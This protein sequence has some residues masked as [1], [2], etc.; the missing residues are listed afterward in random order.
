[1]QTRSRL[2]AVSL[3][4]PPSPAQDIAGMN[5]ELTSAEQIDLARIMDAA[6]NRAREALRVL[7][8]YCRFVLDDAF[9]SGELK[10]L[11][12]ELAQALGEL[13]RDKLLIGRDTLGDVGTRISTAQEGSRAS[14][15]AVVIAN[16]KR[17]QE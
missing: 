2:G 1:M 7:E 6:A 11:R 13:D 8:D 14:T 9:L 15:Q 10:R 17:L 5:H 12:H 4:Q 16:C 3:P